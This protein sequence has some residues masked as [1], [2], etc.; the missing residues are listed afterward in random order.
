MEEKSRSDPLGEFSCHSSVLRLAEMVGLS[1]WAA[2]L[3]PLSLEVVTAQQPKPVDS[4]LLSCGDA[5]YYQSKVVLDSRDWKV[6]V[7]TF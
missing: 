5:Y 6:F 1:L 3:L 7:L 4:N 2:L